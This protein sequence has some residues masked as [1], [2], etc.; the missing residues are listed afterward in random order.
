MRDNEVEIPEP[1]YKELYELCNN[2]SIWIIHKAT[3]KISSMKFLSKS[4]LGHKIKLYVKTISD[5]IVTE[6]GSK[7]ALPLM[8]TIAYFILPFDAVP[9]MMIPIGLLDDLGILTTGY[10][11]SKKLLRASTGKCGS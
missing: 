2:A 10:M 6:Q 5:A 1:F 11:I 8:M 3:E 9:D 7:Y 4:K